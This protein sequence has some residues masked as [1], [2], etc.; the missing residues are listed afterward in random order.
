[1]PYSR[2]PH[3]TR[4]RRHA[5][6]GGILVDGFSITNAASDQLERL[7]KCW[8]ADVVRTP[9]ALLSDI[10]LA[11]LSDITGAITY[12]ALP[13][14]APLRSRSRTSSDTPFARSSAPRSTSSRPPTRQTPTYS[15]HAYTNISFPE[16]L[17]S[18][19]CGA[20]VN[21]CSL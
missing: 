7:L 15:S 11:A 10:Y 17:S 5:K 6:Q 3:P 19:A 12:D 13:P 8:V 18:Q 14:T 9:P 21:M 2:G 4:P 16:I 1:S 20:A